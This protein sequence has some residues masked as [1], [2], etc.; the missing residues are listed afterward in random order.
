LAPFLYRIKLRSPQ[1]Y[2]R[3]VSTVRQ[4]APF[5]DDFVLEPES[6]NRDYIRL[7]WKDLDSEHVFG[8]HQLSDGTLRAIA[9]VSLLRQP[10]NELPSL[11]VLDEPEIGL[12][13]WAV[14]IVA[15]LVR[16]ASVHRTIIVATQSVSL[17]NFFAPEDVVVVTREECQSHFER[18]DPKS[19]KA[20]LDDYLVGDLWEKNVIG[21]MPSR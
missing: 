18:L 3:I 8:P 17:V 1:H 11:I 13:P 20:W 16:S 9:L 2:E 21:G 5:F 4:I 12:H 14:E 6:R 19:L 7:S 15:S 10:E